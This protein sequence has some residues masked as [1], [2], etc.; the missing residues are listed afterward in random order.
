MENQEI[1][2]S[3]KETEVM[4]SCIFMAL[5]EGLYHFGRI[6]IDAGEE[7]VKGILLKFGMSEPEIAK[8][9]EDAG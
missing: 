8:F 5:R 4:K 2:F 7:D 3:Q 6:G 9:M 1:L